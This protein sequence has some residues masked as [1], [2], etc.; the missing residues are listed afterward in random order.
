MKL[1]RLQA[2]VALRNLFK[3][4]KHPRRLLPADFV[5]SSNA[6]MQLLLSAGGAT[7]LISPP[8]DINVQNSSKS[9]CAA[10]DIRP[11]DELLRVRHCQGSTA[12]PREDFY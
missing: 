1:E 5:A 8:S 3:E 10:V 11:L 4:S 12:W 9:N 2:R 6:A 7:M